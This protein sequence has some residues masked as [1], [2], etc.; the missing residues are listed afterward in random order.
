MGKVVVRILGAVAAA[1]ISAMAFGSGVAAADPYAG[2]T[3]ADAASLISSRNQTAVVATVNGDQLATDDCTVVSSSYA[4]FDK[5]SVLLHLNCNAPVAGPGQ[6]GNSAMSPQGRQRIKDENT[7]EAI[8]KKP[9]LCNKSEDVLAWCQ[10]VCDR[11]GMC[12]VSAD[13]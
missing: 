6:P 4:K 8:N 13:S 11:T 2:S 7:A 1:T 10:R 3:Y 5:G 12:E 9:E